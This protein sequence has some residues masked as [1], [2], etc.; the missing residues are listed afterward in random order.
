M[1]DLSVGIEPSVP[2]ADA[3]DAAAPVERASL[4]LLSGEVDLL[5]RVQRVNMVSFMWD[6]ILFGIGFS[7]LNA[8]VLPPQFISQLGGGPLAV[9]LAGLIFR[10]VWLTPQL[11]VAPYVNRAPRKKAFYVIPSL[12]GRSLF[13]PVSIT[14]MLLGPEQPVLLAL[15]MLGGYV[16]LALGDGLGVVAWMD[17]LGSSLSS[18]WRTRMMSWSQA[19]NG[20][21][22]A[23]VVSPLVRFLLGPE[24]PAFPNN[25]ALLLLIAGVLLTVALG[26]Y[27]FIREGNSPPPQDSPGLRQY[28]SFLGRLLRRDAGFRSYI[29]LRICYD[30]SLLGLPFYI[31][32]ATTTMGQQSAVALSDQI[33]LVTVTGV[34]A[35]L[36]LG[37]INERR[38]PHNVL[39]IAT[40]AAT[41]GPLLMLST[42]AIGTPGLHLLWI[43][44]GVLNSSFVPGFLNWIV[45][46]APEGYRP[47]YSGTANTIGA[48]ALVAPMLGGL[49][50]SLISYQALF[51]TGAALGLLA[52]TLAIRLPEPRQAREARGAGRPAA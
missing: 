32:F 11:L 44:V 5:P 13:I 4:P 37:R 42:A 31:V 1:G 33:L 45:E 22:V 27:L 6:S 34:A 48:M 35:A 51:L 3:A 47:I 43:T 24:G 25:Y 15:T 30:F 49:I 28:R 20:L 10:A 29:L 50:V 2:L 38:G 18:T 40:G 52:L 8:S 39:V 36:V 17:L 41:L 19:T 12:P 21:I 16:A 23:L 7:I 9:G 26:S 46:Y 14:M